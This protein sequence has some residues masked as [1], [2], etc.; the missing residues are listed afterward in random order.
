MLSLVVLCA[1]AEKVATIL[2]EGVDGKVKE[3]VELYLAEIRNQ[4]VSTTRLNAVSKLA[5]DALR[6]VG[7]YHAVVDVS[8]EADAET[9]KVDVALGQPVRISHLI[10]DIQGDATHDA[11]FTAVLKQLPIARGQILN[12]GEYES[13]KSLIN[14]Q[15]LELGY[16]DATWLAHKVNVNLAE[17]QAYISLQLDSARR[18]QYGDLQI[19]GNSLSESYIRKMNPLVIGRNY[20]GNA[21]SEFNLELSNTPYYKS[22][23][24]Y[25]DLDKRGFPYVPIRVEISHKPKNSIELG[26]GY[27]TDQREKVRLKWSKPWLFE[28]GH[29]FEANLEASHIEQQL[30]FGYT[31]PVDDPNDDIWRLALGYINEENK[32]TEKYTTQVQRQWRTGENWI[33]SVFVKYERENYRLNDEIRESEMLLPGFSYARKQSFGGTTPYKGLQWLFSIEFASENMASSVNLAKAQ[34]LHQWL[35]TFGK[36]HLIYTRA[37]LGAI[38]TDNLDAVPVSMRFF[39]GGDK[40]IRGFKYESISPVENGEAVGGRYLTTG[41][42]EYN[43]QFKPNWRAAVFIDSGTATNDFEDGLEVGAGFGFRY[44]TPIGPIRVDHAWALSHPD[45]HTRLSITLGPEL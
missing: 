26:G 45:H 20:R 16:F 7:Y 35:Y 38:L 37:Q 10:L 23:R 13:A 4:P 34:M 21:V 27:S 28:Q 29:Y 32:L 36:K 39:A 1:R 17:K 31:M 3:N 40:S 42:L 8:F 15:L 25:A 18:Y 19:T 22:V 9:L 44:L 11:E 33:K 30:R 24:V 6:A 43:Y 2:V 14:V 41:T 12:H 5:Q